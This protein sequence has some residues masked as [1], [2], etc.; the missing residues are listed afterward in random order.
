MGPWRSLI[1]QEEAEAAKPGRWRRQ[2]EGQRQG[3]SGGLL[4]RG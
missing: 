2:S 4:E 1:F 3:Q